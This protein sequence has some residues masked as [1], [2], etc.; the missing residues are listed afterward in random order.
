MIFSYIVSELFEL[1]Q[2]E[3]LL[4]IAISDQQLVPDYP[5]KSSEVFYFINP[6]IRQSIQLG[7]SSNLQTQFDETAAEQCR[8][9]RR[10]DSALAS[11]YSRSVSL[12]CG[13]AWNPLR[14]GLFKNQS[15]TY[16]LSHAVNTGTNLWETVTR[17]YQLHRPHSTHKLVT[18]PNIF[19]ISTWAIGRGTK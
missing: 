17:K 12:R 15:Q 7:L 18:K 9:K 10:S 11:R 1:F 2:A 8:S 14:V 19:A 6:Y 16:C 13:W 5:S 3:I 4:T